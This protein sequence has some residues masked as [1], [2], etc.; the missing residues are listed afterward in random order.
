MEGL[1]SDEEGRR[2]VPFVFLGCVA[3]L[4]ASLSSEPDSGTTLVA[5]NHGILRG[6]GQGARGKK[7]SHPFERW[8]QGG[9]PRKCLGGGGNDTGKETAFD[10]SRGRQQR[11]YKKNVKLAP[12]HG[13]GDGHITGQGGMRLQ[14]IEERKKKGG[15][16][17]SE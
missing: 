1:G 16:R 8:F 13:R 5:V 7:E 12:I 3:F 6:R 14:D 11:S 2:S 15:R 10:A 4:R 9:D 17:L